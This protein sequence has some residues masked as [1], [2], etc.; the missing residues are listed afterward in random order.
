MTE[1]SFKKIAR[2]L[3]RDLENCYTEEQMLFIE[4]RLKEI[5][6][7]NNLSSNDIAYFCD[8]NSSE[9][10]SYI[11]DYKNFEENFFEKQP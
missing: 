5:A 9:M 4:Q 2:E 10:F 11:F 1:N 3:T 7:E 6:E 8:L